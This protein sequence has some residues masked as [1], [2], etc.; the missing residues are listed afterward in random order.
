MYNF[1]CVLYM[2][3]HRHAAYKMLVTQLCQTL[4]DPLDCS[5]PG[6][7]IHRISKA[8]ILEWVGIYFSR[9][10][11][12]PR[13]WTHISCS[14]FQ[15]FQHTEL[16]GLLGGWVLAGPSCVN[17]SPQLAAVFAPPPHFPQ[18]PL[19]KS[20]LASQSEWPFFTS[21]LATVSSALITSDDLTACVVFSR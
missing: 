3:I 5:P 9:G 20:S 11:S 8:R 15:S 13:D 12:Q 10:S 4:C 19:S 17:P 14:F 7:S 16:M 18:W 2:C 6:S 1:I 21:L